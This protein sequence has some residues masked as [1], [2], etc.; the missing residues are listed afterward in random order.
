MFDKSTRLLFF[1]CLKDAA[2]AGSDLQKNR[3][4]L[5]SR[6][7]ITG[8]LFTHKLMFKKKDAYLYWK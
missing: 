3:L 5:R 8:I 1:A 7:K 4:Q 6:P 2:G